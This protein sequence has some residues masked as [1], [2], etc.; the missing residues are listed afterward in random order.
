MTTAWK[1]P[2]RR[3][4]ARLAQAE[5]VALLHKSIRDMRELLQGRVALLCGWGGKCRGREPIKKAG[6]LRLHDAG[7]A[8]EAQKDA[9]EADVAATV[10]VA[11]QRID[12]LQQAV[13]VAQRQQ[14]PGSGGNRLNEQTAAHFHGMVRCWARRAHIPRG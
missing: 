6:V 13:M 10:K 8:S 14:Q 11:A 2:C 5:D 7:Q 3:C 1:S 9:F 12:K 4:L